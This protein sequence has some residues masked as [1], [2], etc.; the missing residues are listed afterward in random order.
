MPEGQAPRWTHDCPTCEFLGIW[1]DADRYD[2]YVCGRDNNANTV[3]ARWGPQL[4]NYLSG[5]IAA[6]PHYVLREAWLRAKAL[7][8][9]PPAHFKED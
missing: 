5:L 2:L 9:K 6:N 7:G 1:D 8:W 3:V 4:G